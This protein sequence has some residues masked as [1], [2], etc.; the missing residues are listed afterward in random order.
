MRNLPQRGTRLLRAAKFVTREDTDDSNGDEEGE[1]KEKGGGGRKSPEARQQGQRQG[2][3]GPW[4]AGPELQSSSK[5]V[6]PHKEK[7][8]Q[9]G[10]Q[11]VR[12]YVAKSFGR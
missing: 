5:V 3:Q 1:I 9:K 7:N 10:L 11:R 12:C 2:D 4:T 8:P 6:S